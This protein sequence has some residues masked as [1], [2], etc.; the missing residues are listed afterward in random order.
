MS[1]R[2]S[3]NGS[4][5]HR[6]SGGLAGLSR[7]VSSG[8]GSS[9]GSLSSIQ[10]WAGSRY[11]AA[12]Q[13]GSCR[14]D[15]VVLGASLRQQHE[16]VCGPVPPEALDADARP[17]QLLQEHRALVERPQ[18]HRHHVLHAARRELGDAGRTGRVA[19][20]VAHQVAGGV[21]HVA[22][23]HDDALVLGESLEQVLVRKRLERPRLEGI[24]VRA[25]HPARPA[26][27]CRWS[28][29]RP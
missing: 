22:R 26:D 29:H 5:R 13:L 17:Q 12:Q 25:G 19:P 14:G 28:G 2:S 24:G 11:G 15:K 4:T 23:Q 8:R 10:P 16:V 21:V 20:P 1:G 3:S 27:L 9:P 7:V 18:V 6:Q